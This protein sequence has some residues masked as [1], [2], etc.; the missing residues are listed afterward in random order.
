MTSALVRPLVLVVDDDQ[1]TR[2]MYAMF[3]ESSGVAVLTAANVEAAFHAALEHQPQV[4]ITDY[5]L[6]GCATGADLCRRLRDNE[7]TAHIPALV[8]TGSTRKGDAEAALD[9]GCADIRLKPYLPDA[10]LN[11]IREIIGRPRAQRLMG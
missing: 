1:D 2:D 10:L 8:V 11:D 6:P 3:L 5:L 9:A 4:I 7:R